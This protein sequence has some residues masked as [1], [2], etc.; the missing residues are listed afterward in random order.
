MLMARRA[1]IIFCVL[2]AA[3]FAWLWLTRPVKVDMAAYVPADSIIYFEAN[4][5]QD[6]FKA[7][8][9]TDDWKELAPAAGVEINRGGGERLTDL[10]SF[11]GIGPSDA[12]V[13]SRA[14]VAVAI[15]GFEAA[16][17]GDSLNYKPRAA[18]VVETHTS[19]W[20]VKSAVETL[21]GDF[22]GRS[23]EGGVTVERKEGDEVP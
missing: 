3:I 16:E 4:S 1:L 22:A 20:R 6:I 23:F 21:V 2:A 7:F 19:E 15:L 12:V 18:L 9:S 17:A 11:T 8:T 13:L 14:Q 5:L 10:I